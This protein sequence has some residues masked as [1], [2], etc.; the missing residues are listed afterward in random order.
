MAA[1]ATA[2]A[3]ENAESNQP[4][5]SATQI[6]DPRWRPVL[7]LPCRLTVDLLLPSFKV[8]DFLALR[9]GSIVA[10]SWGVTRDVPLRINGILIGWAE[11]EGTGMRLAVRVTELA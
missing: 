7:A 8:A 5:Q 9:A 1:A 3:V 10:T 6:E 4:A 11:L 2:K